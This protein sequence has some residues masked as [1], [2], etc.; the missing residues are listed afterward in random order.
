MADYH[1]IVTYDV[2]VRAH[3]LPVLSQGV[4][5]SCLAFEWIR[6]AVLGGNDYYY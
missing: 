5:V 2:L 6:R 1:I 3:L 4:R